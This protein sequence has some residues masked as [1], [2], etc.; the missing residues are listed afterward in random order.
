MDTKL[1]RLLFRL[2]TWRG[3]PANGMPEEGYIDLIIAV[4]DDLADMLGVT[5]KQREPLLNPDEVEDR[6]GKVQAMLKDM[7]G[8]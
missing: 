6:A 4:S 2:D 1:H 8:F 7:E 5:Y 3:A